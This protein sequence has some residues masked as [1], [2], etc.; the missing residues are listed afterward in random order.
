MVARRQ[1][2]RIL[3]ATKVQVANQLRSIQPGLTGAQILNVG[4]SSDATFWFAQLE[5]GFTPF[6]GI[7]QNI[8]TYVEFDSEFL[9]T[10]LISAVDPTVQ[11]VDIIDFRVSQIDPLSLEIELTRKR[12]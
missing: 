11:P 1:Q 3:K 9:I 8:V 5:T 12:I 2:T 7:T 10:N 4:R 6:N